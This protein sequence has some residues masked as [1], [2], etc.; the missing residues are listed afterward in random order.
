MKL[1]R[2]MFSCLGN[3]YYDYR[4]YKYYSNQFKKSGGGINQKI[5]GEDEYIR[6][7]KSLGK[8]VDRYQYRLFSQYVGFT[9]YIVPEDIGRRY[10]EKFLN[11]KRFRPFYS[12]KNMYDLVMDISFTPKTYIR[13]INGSNLLGEDYKPIQHNIDDLLKTSKGII[14]KPSIDTAGGLGVCLFERNDDGMFVNKKTKETLS[15][16][17]LLNSGKNFIVQ[18][19]VVQSSSISIFCK[20]AINTLRISV[21][22]SVKDESLNILG[23]VLRIGKQG[24]IVDNSHSGGRFVAVDINTGR[25]GKQVFDIYGNHTNSWNE[26]DFSASEYTIPNWNSVIEFAKKCVTV[27][28]IVGYSP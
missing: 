3:L 2:T 12:D 16:S 17:F 8:F 5:K 14:L 23:C 20:T 15:S 4:Y 21:Y 9:P 25:V 18:E 28:I 26:V 19:A 1:I 6:K 22:R 24:E 10:L 27:I 7:W 11:P 13:R